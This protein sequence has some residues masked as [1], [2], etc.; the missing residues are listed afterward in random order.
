MI[1]QNLVGVDLGKIVVHQG[2]TFLRLGGSNVM[3]SS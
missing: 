1:N 3:V 2:M